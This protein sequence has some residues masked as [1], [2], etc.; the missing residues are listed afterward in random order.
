MKKIIIILIIGCI[1][2]SLYAQRRNRQ[3]NP[4][5]RVKK[6]YTETIIVPTSTKDSIK[7]INFI[8]IPYKTVTFTTNPNPQSNEEN[9]YAEINI[10][11]NFKNQENIIKGRTVQTKRLYTSDNSEQNLTDKQLNTCMETVLPIGNYRPNLELLTESN[12]Q[13]HTERLVNINT[14]NYYSK[15]NI[16]NP[17]FTYK[18]DYQFIP[19]ILD[20][21][22]SYNSSNANILLLVSYKNEN[23]NFKYIIRKLDNIEPRF[24]FG[25]KDLVYNANLKPESGKVLELDDNSSEYALKTNSY[26]NSELIFSILEIDIENKNMIPGNYQLFVV[27]PEIKDT[28]KFNFSINWFEQPMSLNNPII[29]AEIMYFVLNDKEFEKLKDTDNDLKFD[30]INDYWKSKDPTTNTNYNEAMAEYYKRVDYSNENFK[31]NVDEF[32]AKSE[33]G[34]IY[35][36]YGKPDKTETQPKSDYTLE[37]WTYNKIKKEFVFESSPSGVYKLIQINDL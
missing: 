23:S 37:L 7:V 11:I 15:A 35:I 31:S 34:K 8:K 19:Y 10:E 1:F 26:N 5:E 6:V 30:A 22:I 25:K 4:T 27:H 2:N 9:F 32:G 24:S 21:A 17:I 36:L 28:F 13:I 12:I 16:Y 29:S 18:Q 14:L 3:T 33:R 20:S